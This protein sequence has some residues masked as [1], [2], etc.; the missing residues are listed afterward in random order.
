MIATGP[1]YRCEEHEPLLDRPW[2]EARVRDA[3]AGIVAEHE[4]AFDDGWPAHPADELD[5]PVESVYLGTAGVLWALHRLG[6]RLDAGALVGDALERYRASPDADGDPHPPSLLLG[7]TGILL[8]ADIVGSPAADRARLAELV[9]ANAE[10][11]SWELL[12]GSPGT[13]LA[14][15]RAGLD[16]LA[17]ESAGLLAERWEHDGLWT[18]TLPGWEAQILGPAHGLAGNVHALRGFLPDAEL[19]ERVAPALDATALRDGGRANWPPALLYEPHQL[20]VQWCHG[21]PGIVATIGDLMPAELAVAGG[22]LTWHAGPL[23]KGAGLCH[24]TAGNG[25]TF[26]K[27]LTLTGDERWLDR[28]RRFAI[29]ALAQVEAA[30]AALGRGRY[31]LFTGDIGVALFARACLDG[32][33]A[34][35]TMDVW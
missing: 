33:P 13:I 28:A 4:S 3:I 17:D 19:R 35:P 7:E 23:A 20:R 12:Y 27:L 10:H 6:T 11:P 16:E 9:A 15:R 31:S 34:F 5:E 22:E 18:Q 24:G 14:A 8:V 29:H 25:W 32:D 21:A 26:L 30:R 2:D 1:I